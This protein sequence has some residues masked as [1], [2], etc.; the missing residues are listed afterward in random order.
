MTDV[1]RFDFNDAHIAILSRSNAAPR[2]RSRRSVSFAKSTT[3]KVFLDAAKSINGRADGKSFKRFLNAKNFG[4]DAQTLAMKT[5]CN[6]I[7]Q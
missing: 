1:C 4:A 3:A 2:R 7:A 6:R 5:S